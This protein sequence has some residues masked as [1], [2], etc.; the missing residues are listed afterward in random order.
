VDVVEKLLFDTIYHEHVSYHTLGPLKRFF[1]SVS[2]RLFD[3]ERVDTH[4]GSIRGYACRANANHADSEQ[5][6]NLLGSERKG[7]FSSSDLYTRFKR[8]VSERGT[9]LRRRVSDILGSGQHVAGFGAPAKLT[10]LMYE[11]GLDGKSIDFIVDDSPWKQ[12]LYTPGTHIPVLSSAAL[13][14]RRPEWCVIF[15]WNFADPIIDKQ[16]AYR[17]RGGRFL[18]PLP[19]LREI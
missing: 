18:V 15:A 12:G 17:E 1:E 9:D 16:A 19:E 5:L 3:A 14:E 11:F 13:L 7:G 4:G 2:M 10:T 8:R 6:T